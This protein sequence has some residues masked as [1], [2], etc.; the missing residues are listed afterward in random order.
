MIGVAGTVTSLAALT[1]GLD[2]YDRGVVH[3]ARVRAKD[4][5]LTVDRLARLSVEERRRLTS[6]ETRR[7]DVI[8]VGGYWLLAILRWLERSPHLRAD[9]LVASDRGVRFGLLSEMAMGASAEP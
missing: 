5:A 7:A 2:H 3:G 6:L 9:A 1:L 8:V 4:L